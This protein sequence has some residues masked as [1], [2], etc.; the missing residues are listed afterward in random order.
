MQIMQSARV[1]C[2]M[3]GTITNTANNN[4]TRLIYNALHGI[5]THYIALIGLRCIV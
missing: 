5:A 4:S 1:E 3:V 2:S